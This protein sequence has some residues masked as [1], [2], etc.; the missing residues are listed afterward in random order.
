MRLKFLK[1][2]TIHMFPEKR[3]ANDQLVIQHPFSER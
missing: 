1:E 3:D 2:E